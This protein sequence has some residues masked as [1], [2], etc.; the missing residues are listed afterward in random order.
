MHVRA[1]LPPLK[2]QTSLKIIAIPLEWTREQVSAQN[3]CDTSTFHQKN[4]ISG[5]YM[6]RYCTTSYVTVENR[7][8]HE[9]SMH[10]N[11]YMR[12]DMKYPTKSCQ[13]CHTPFLDDKSYK[14]HLSTEHELEIHSHKKARTDLDVTLTFGQNDRLEELKDSLSDLVEV[15]PKHF[16]VTFVF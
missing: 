1:A 14:S 15:T 8:T 6:C 3:T 11:D 16:T 13:Y 5:P 9:L 12:T 4:L 10:K 2:Q 7:D